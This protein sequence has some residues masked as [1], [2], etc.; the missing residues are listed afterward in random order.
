MY[1]TGLISPPPPSE[2]LLQLGQFFRFVEN[3]S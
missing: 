1:F 3:T 2:Y